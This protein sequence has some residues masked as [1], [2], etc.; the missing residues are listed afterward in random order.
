MDRSYVG[1]KKM[2]SVSFILGEAFSTAWNTRK[3]DVKGRQRLQDK[4]IDGASMEE[5]KIIN[6]MLHAIRRGWI[7][8]SD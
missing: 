5:Q 4:L 3:L 2:R 7:E 8:V 1:N 6:R